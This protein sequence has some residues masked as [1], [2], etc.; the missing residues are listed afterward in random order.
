MYSGH[1]FLISTSAGRIEE[2]EA[3]YSLTRAKLEP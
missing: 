1:H 3:G 2:N